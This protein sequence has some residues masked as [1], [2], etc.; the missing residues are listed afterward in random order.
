MDKWMDGWMDRRS[1]PR[2]S[3]GLPPSLTSDDITYITYPPKN[4]YRILDEVVDYLIPIARAYRT[5]VRVFQAQ[6]HRDESSLRRSRC[7]W[8][9]F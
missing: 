1:R 8:C 7:G 4:R 5:R 2:R 9:V 3:I 6:L